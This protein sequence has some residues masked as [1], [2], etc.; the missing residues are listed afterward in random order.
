MGAIRAQLSRIACVML[1]AL[2]SFPSRKNAVMAKM[3]DIKWFVN[4]SGPQSFTAVVAAATPT[5]P[6]LDN[7]TATRDVTA[8]PTGDLSITGNVTP[9]PLTPGASAFYMFDVS[10]GG[11]SSLPPGAT[12]TMSP[13]MYCIYGTNGFTGLGGSITGTGVMIYLQ[14]GDFGLGGTAL[15]AL[16]AEQAAGV[17]LDASQNDWRGMLVYVDPSNSGTVNLTGNTGTTY[18]GAIYAPGSQCT[19]N[20]TGDSIGLLNSQIICDKVK[21]TGTAQVT[22]DL[23]END[24]YALPSSIDLAK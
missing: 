8:V 20:G 16:A 12:V 2:R 18:T 9:R 10:N 11:P 23:S 15:V 24:T 5:D 22:F 19:I 14:A 6:D 7:N 21:I 3:S 1:S 4:A 17:L 13:G